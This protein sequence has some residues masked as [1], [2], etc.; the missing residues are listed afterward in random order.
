MIEF[1]IVVRHAVLVVALYHAAV[2]P[3]AVHLVVADIRALALH[4]VPVLLLALA[5]LHHVVLHDIVVAVIVKMKMF[6]LA[7]VHLKMNPVEEMIVALQQI[8]AVPVLLL[9]VL[10]RAGNDSF[11]L[12][13]NIELTISIL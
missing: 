12:I 8:V 6:V 13:L 2:L 4:L 1:R 10:L 7:L 11:I 5:L 9:L 3:V